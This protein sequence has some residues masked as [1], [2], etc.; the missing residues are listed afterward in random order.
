MKYFKNISPPIS[1]KSSPHFYGCASVHKDRRPKSSKALRINTFFLFTSDTSWML[2]GQPLSQNRLCNGVT[3]LIPGRR[4][5]VP[6]LENRSP[7][8]FEWDTPWRS[9]G[10][11]HGPES[12]Q[13]QPD[14]D[15]NAVGLHFCTAKCARLLLAGSRVPEST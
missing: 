9:S 14:F 6:K 8:T 1:A 7:S 2:L 11:C 13:Q 5:T 4:R 3:D 12:R 10:V 15:L